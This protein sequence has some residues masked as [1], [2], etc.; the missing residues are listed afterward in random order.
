MFTCNDLSI[1]ILYIVFLLETNEVSPQK[2]H[3]KHKH[4]KHKKRKVTHNDND[5]FNN[6][7]TE[8]EKKKMFRVKI[9]KDDEKG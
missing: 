7:A 1:F 4:K 6:V 5:G 9:K 8:T 2:R 3:K